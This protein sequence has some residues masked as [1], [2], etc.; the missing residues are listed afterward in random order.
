MRRNAEDTRNLIDLELTRFQ[1]LRLFR[2]NPDGCILHALFENRDLVRVRAALICR[3]PA[4][5]DAQRVFD[6]AGMFQHACRSR[7]VGEELRAVLFGSDRQADRVLRHGNRAVADQA[8]EPEPGDVQYVR[9][10]K[11]HLT[12]FPECGRVLRPALIQ[13]KKPAVLITVDCHFARH[14]WVE[15]D[16]LASG[17]SDDLCVG[18]AP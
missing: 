13:I 3:V 4:F 5:L 7:A 8:V 1:K 2:R 18:V 14:E 12:R 11:G 15:R 9:R 16:H 6:R 10:R 17:V